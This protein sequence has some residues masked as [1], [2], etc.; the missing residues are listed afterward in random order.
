L[1]VS[2]TDSMIW[3]SGL[4]DWVPCPLRLALAGGPQQADAI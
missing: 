2:L 1:K 3:R 4:K